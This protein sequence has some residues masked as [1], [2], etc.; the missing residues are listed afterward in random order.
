MI[1][2]TDRLLYFCLIKNITYS[3]KNIETLN[4][5]K[6]FDIVT[7]KKT[8]ADINL[9]KSLSQLELLLEKYKK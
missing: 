3:K 6:K 7:A 4:S 2:Y 1:H 8:E 5:K 9:I